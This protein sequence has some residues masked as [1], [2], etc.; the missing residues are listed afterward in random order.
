MYN[1][2]QQNN[3]PDITKPFFAY[4]IFRPGEISFLGI[5]D[6]IASIEK[7][8]LNGDLYWWDGINLFKPSLKSKEIVPGYKIKFKSE[9]STQA[10]DFIEEIEPSL[11]YWKIIR[12]QNVLAGV[13]SYDTLETFHEV[14]CKSVWEDPYFNLNNGNSVINYL[15]NY[16][17]KDDFS[18]LSVFELQMHYLALWSVIE[19]F[20]TLRYGTTQGRNKLAKSQYFKDKLEE[21]T[22]EERRIIY[23]TQDDKRLIL[24]A[25]NDDRNEAAERCR[26]LSE[27]WELEQS[28]AYYYQI[29]CNITHRGKALSRDLEIIKKSFNELLQI[30]EYVLIET[31]KECEKIKQKY[32]RRT[33]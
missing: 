24:N 13:I 10:Y 19:R 22:K 5:K 33:N 32:E 28:I 8:S 31:K 3:L 16:K 11:Y 18:F 6:C 23:S 17:S 1:N 14:E 21:V 27:N 25:T 12:D 4:G 7:S 9:K 15:K 30:M 26:N 2:Y 20:I 29:R